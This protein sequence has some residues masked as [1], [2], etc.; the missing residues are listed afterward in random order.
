MSP[1]PYQSQGEPLAERKILLGVSGGIACYKVASLCSKLVQAGACVRVIM[2]PASRRFI[3]PVT[4]QALSGQS[5]ITSIWQFD[6]HLPSQHISLARW[7]HAMVIAPA[8]A[9]LIAKLAAGLCNDAVHLAA[10]ALPRETPLLLAP[11]M[12]QQM[13]ENPITQRN[14]NTLTELLHCEVVGPETG[15]QACRTVGPGRMSEPP[16]ILDAIIRALACDHG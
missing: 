6:H 7:C 8:T 1:T 2:T 11:A 5:V 4:F 16:I 10:A 14:L 15:W 12:N 9:D 13:W 3:T